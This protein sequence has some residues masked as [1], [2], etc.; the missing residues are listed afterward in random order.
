MVHTFAIGQEGN[1]DVRI[2]RAER[3]LAYAMAG[4]AAAMGLAALALAFA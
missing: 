1:I 2:A 3:L 4:A